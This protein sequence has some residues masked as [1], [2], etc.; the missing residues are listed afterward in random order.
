MPPCGCSTACNAPLPAPHRA[1]RQRMRRQRITLAAPSVA[2]RGVAAPATAAGAAHHSKPSCASFS[3]MAPNND[4]RPTACNPPPGGAA[5]RALLH[6]A[7]R[8]ASQTWRHS[9]SAPYASSCRKIFLCHWP[10]ALKGKCAPVA[11]MAYDNTTV[12]DGD[13]SGVNPL[14]ARKWSRT[15]GGAAPDTTGMRKSGTYVNSNNLIWLSILEISRTWRMPTKTFSKSSRFTASGRPRT[16]CPMRGQSLTTLSNDHR[17][18]VSQT[19]S[20]EC[21]NKRLCCKLKGSK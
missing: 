21:N 3:T 7:S 6:G 18:V 16:I 4:A 5:P 19:S 10:R 20:T 2:S 14:G 8:S 13:S 12:E 17:H 1:Q 11:P 9:T 15:Q